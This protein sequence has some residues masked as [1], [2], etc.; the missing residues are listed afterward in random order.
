MHATREALPCRRWEEHRALRQLSFDYAERMAPLAL[1]RSLAP[2][3]ELVPAH[4]VLLALYGVPLV[5]CPSSNGII[6]EL[7]SSLVLQRTCFW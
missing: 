1:A 2:E 7:Q 3:L 5:Q 4:D 6:L